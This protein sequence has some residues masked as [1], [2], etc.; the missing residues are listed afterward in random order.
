VGLH[1]LAKALQPKALKLPSAAL[2]D[3]RCPWCVP[4]N[5]ALGGEAMADPS[6]GWCDRQA[7]SL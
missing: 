3:D 1:K 7:E 2:V 6:N 5:L 4:L